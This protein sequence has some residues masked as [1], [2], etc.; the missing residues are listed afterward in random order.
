MNTILN[1]QDLLIVKLL[2][3][4]RWRINRA[5]GV[6][7]YRNFQPDKPFPK[8]E[9]LG[10]SG[11]MA[12][13]KMVGIWFP[14]S[15]DPTV[16]VREADLYFGGRSI[17]IKTTENHQYQ[18][19]NLTIKEWEDTKSEVYA[20]MYRGIDMVTFNYMGY[21]LQENLIR[22]ELRKAGKKY[23]DGSQA[24]DYYSLPHYQLIKSLP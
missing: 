14:T 11:E 19:L 6:K 7:K 10:I 9:R 1:E 16:R 12:F 15:Q 4:E 13:A 17:D 3:E 23:P 2:Q 22:P 20:L 8:T 21:A 5:L 18:N 24:P